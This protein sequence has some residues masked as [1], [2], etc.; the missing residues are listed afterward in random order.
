MINKRANKLILTVFT[1]CLCAFCVGTCFAIY[2]NNADTVEIGISATSNSSTP[3]PTVYTFK[4]PDYVS[5]AGAT[6]G[7]WM[8]AGVNDGDRWL[9]ATYVENSG[10]YSYY[11][12]STTTDHTKAT[13]LRFKSGY[14]IQLDGANATNWYPNGSTDNCWNKSPD[15][16]LDSNNVIDASGNWAG[17]W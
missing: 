12:V 4:C 2:N 7:V 6:V 10:G 14:T 5:S 13:L 11:T 1:I 3:Q 16:Y 17:S 15:V 8:N 9:A